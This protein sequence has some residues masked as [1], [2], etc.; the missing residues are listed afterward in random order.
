MRANRAAA[1]YICGDAGIEGWHGCVIKAERA[2]MK[3]HAPSTDL[4]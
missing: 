3:R 1:K 4:F 2:K